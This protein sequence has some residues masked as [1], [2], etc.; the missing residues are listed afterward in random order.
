[1]LMGDILSLAAANWPERVALV[2]GNERRTFADLHA[3]SLRLA[4]GLSRIASPGDRIA[5]LARNVPAYVEALYGVPTAGMVLTLLN[6]RIHPREWAEIIAAAGAR[7]LIVDREFVD[8]LWPVLGDVPAIEHMFVIG[9]PSDGR[10]SSYE[11]LVAS[12]SP[13]RPQ[14]EV[15]DSDTAWLVYTS[16]TTGSPK[17]AMITHRGIITA[18]MTM[19]LAV[20]PTDRDRMLMT[21]PMCHVSAFQ[22]PTYHLCGVPTVLMPAFEPSAFLE[23]VAE[24]RITIT[25]LAPTMAAF[26]LRYPGY[27]TADLSSIRRL[28]YGGMAMPTSTARALADRLGPVLVTGFGQTESTGWVTALSPEDHV[29]ALSGQEQLLESCG[30]PLPL[31][32][33]AVMDEQMRRCPAGTP[34][35]LVIRGD[36][37]TSGYWNDEKATAA[38]F[39]DGWLHTGDVATVDK[40]GYVYLVDRIKDMI[41]T[42]GQ[43]VYSTQVEQVLH[44]HEAVSEAAVI[45]VPDP[46]WGESVVAVIV[47]RPGAHV[48]PED[49]LRTC[50]AQ[51]AGY[52]SPRKI[53]V[54]AELPKNITGKVLKRELRGRY[55]PATAL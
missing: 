4:D 20:S 15:S 49:I 40:E 3:D 11:E 31:T 29:R 36:L 46:V 24:H 54:V 42:G 27:D 53:H 32:A 25:S 30:R 7:V 18:A 38:A 44:K 43:N 22:V 14:V 21:F 13:I 12:A 26:V 33:V 37:V 17:G 2:T 51:L 41:I 50:R 55:A 6:Y 35:E 5:I 45:G 1:M 10:G 16:G 47:P 23:L 48:D 52:K 19:M 8:E 28:G 39:T 34:G 9:G